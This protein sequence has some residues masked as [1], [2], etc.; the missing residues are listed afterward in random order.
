MNDLIYSNFIGP[1]AENIKTLA[2]MI[3]KVVTHH[4]QMRKASFPEDSSLYPDNKIDNSLLESEL[5]SLLEKSKKNFPYHHPRYIAQMLKDPSIPTILGYLTFMLSNPNNHAYEGGPVTTELEMEVIEMMK[6]LTGFENGWGH[7]ASGGSLAN[8]EALWA[9][10]DFYKKGSVY[11]SEVSHYSWKR[12]CNI[13]RIEDYS[14][15]PVDNNFR[16]ELN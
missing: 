11:F 6:R 12:I 2:E 7:L 15:I 4:S 1:K 5:S 3:N 9:A 8:M 13:L 16:I 14:E 10:R